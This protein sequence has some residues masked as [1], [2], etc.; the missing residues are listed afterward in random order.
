MIYTEFTSKL[1]EHL[2]V[3]SKDLQDESEENRREHHDFFINN[4]LD[5]NEVVEI[6]IANG[7]IKSKDDITF[8]NGGFIEPPSIDGVV[9]R[10]YTPEDWAETRVGN[11]I[12]DERHLNSLGSKGIKATASEVVDKYRE[13][14]G[15]MNNRIY[16]AETRVG[17]LIVDDIVWNRSGT[18][19]LDFS[20]SK[21]RKR[22]S[23]KCKYNRRSRIFSAWDSVLNSN[24]ITDLEKFLK[25]VNYV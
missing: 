11:L 22:K 9:N 17:D 4:I 12:V 7:I 16:T 20:P 23:K 25:R 18:I 13:L 6:G 14:A 19:E 3:H 5:F 24:P 15:S 1:I 2:V 8:N 21:L 10:F